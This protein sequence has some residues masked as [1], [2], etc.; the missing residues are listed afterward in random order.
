LAREP[1]V[2]RALAVRRLRKEELHPRIREDV[3]ALFHRGKYD[4]AV[5]EAMKA[6]EVS[7]REAA[8]YTNADH[9]KDMIARAF[10]PKTGPLRDDTAE[11]GR[12]YLARQS[13]LAHHQRSRR[14]ADDV[15]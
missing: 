12:D 9:G 1:D 8:E 10:N 14:T 13:P 15:N 11:G 2:R 4:T 7:V 3:W 5:F 6:V